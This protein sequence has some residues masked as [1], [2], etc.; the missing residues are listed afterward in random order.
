MV[1]MKCASSEGAWRCSA[2]GS[3]SVFIGGPLRSWT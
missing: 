1:V 2:A 3:V